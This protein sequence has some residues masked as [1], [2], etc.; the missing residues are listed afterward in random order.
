MASTSIAKLDDAATPAPAASASETSGS[1]SAASSTADTSASPLLNDADTTAAT[2]VADSE[3]KDEHRDAEDPAGPESAKRKS[4]GKGK[5]TE[6]EET[7][8]IL[9]DEPGH[10]KELRTSSTG[11]QYAIETRGM[12]TILRSLN[13]RAG[14][15]LSVR[16]RLKKRLKEVLSNDF[17]MPTFYMLMFCTFSLPHSGPFSFASLRKSFSSGNGDSLFISSG[18]LSLALFLHFEYISPPA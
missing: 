7:V 18:R 2:S 5:A 4:K 10:R 12:W 1:I 13:P 15:K 16:E 8:K 6:V 11:R 9:I 3:A 17:D 14:S